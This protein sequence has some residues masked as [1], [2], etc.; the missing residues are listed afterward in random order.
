M[1]GSPLAADEHDIRHDGSSWLD[2]LPF[3]VLACVA[4]WVTLPDLFDVDIFKAALTAIVGALVVLPLLVGPARARDD[5]TTWFSSGI[6]RGLVLVT[7]VSAI[8][9]V[10][11]LVHA[12]VVDRLLVFAVSQMAALAG[13]RAARARTGLFTGV[14]LAATTPVAVV[15]LTQALGWTSAL[16]PG[17]EEV[18]S[19]LGNSTRAG[20]LLALGIP[21]AVMLTVF[22]VLRR[23]TIT[24]GATLAALLVALHTAACLLT[25]ARG[26]RLAVLAG[27]VVTVAFVVLASTRGRLPR[28]QSARL[29]RA[30]GT[31]GIAL[32]IGVG[33]AAFT[34][35]DQ[36]WTARKLDTSAPILSGTDLTTNVRLSLWDATL[37]MT[38]DHRMFGVGLGR[39]GEVFPRYR[40][41]VEAALPG[42]AGATTVAQHPHNEA[43]FVF[44]EG[45]LVAGAILVLLLAA[46]MRR[47][48]L[49]AVS[50][51]DC[52]DLAATGVVTAGF[53]LGMV[54]DAWTTVGTAVP[55]FAALGLLW[56]VPWTARH[57]LQDLGATTPSRGARL[58]LAAVTAL[59]ALALIGQAVPRLQTH[60]GLREFYTQA[61]ALEARTSVS[62]DDF[63]AAFATLIEAADADPTDV[64][65]QQLVIHFG[66]G[67]LAQ[68]ESAAITAA[69]ERSRKRLE[70]LRPNG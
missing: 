42:L 40:D 12:S 15:A 11:V 9:S 52:D 5:I 19:L 64:A 28:E 31:A 51:P 16:T 66:T 36:V 60:L 57:P 46:T 59:A 24:L 33:L 38:A 37:D 29:S 32:A 55:I 27:L 34:N 44:A 67:A 35:P 13:L 18:V 69:V 43:L 6:G 65:A 47:T 63:E 20:A 45:G 54:Q 39:Y 2:I 41:P 14:L 30:L 17:P 61:A 23:G 3:A 70:V 56:S 53:A 49:R 10:T 4:A 50:D 48:W 1:S 26:A 62:I 8:G 58:A 22:T 68:T 21:A 25:L 7:A